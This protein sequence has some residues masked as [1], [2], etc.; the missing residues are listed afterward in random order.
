MYQKKRIKNL[1]FSKILVENKQKRKNLCL[2]GDLLL[3][4][5]LSKYCIFFSEI[6]ESS[7]FIFNILRIS[8]EQRRKRGESE[9]SVKRELRARGGA[10]KNPA[11]H[12]TIV[13]AV[14]EFKY[15]RSYP[16]SYFP[17]RDP[18]TFFQEVL[19]SHTWSDLNQQLIDSRENCMCGEFNWKYSRVGLLCSL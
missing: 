18:R 9:A 8:G 7:H 10:L 11:C 19:R 6:G 16:I 4:T 14:P 5:Q 15:E 17:S 2:A 3:E 1:S 13:R 12:H